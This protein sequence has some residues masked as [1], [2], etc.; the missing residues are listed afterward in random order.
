[1]R[2]LIPPESNR[3]PEYPV[4]DDSSQPPDGFAARAS[5]TPAGTQPIRSGAPPGRSSGRNGTPFDV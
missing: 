3:D 2:V 4:Q 5:V 1:M